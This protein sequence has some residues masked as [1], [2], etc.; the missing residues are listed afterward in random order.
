M[1]FDAY[2]DK[3][4]VC[5]LVAR[6]RIRM[7]LGRH[8]LKSMMLLSEIKKKKSKN[9]TS[10]ARELTCHRILRTTRKVCGR[11]WIII[12]AFKCAVVRMLQ[13]LNDSEKDC[14]YDFLA[15]LNVDFDPLRVQILWKEDFLS[16]K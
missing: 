9:L 13:F 10:Q 5:F 1:E 16:L 4:Y 6:R 7:P 2:K 14:I 8:I 15:Y 3:Q 11:R 12:N